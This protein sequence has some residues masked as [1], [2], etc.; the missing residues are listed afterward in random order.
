MRPV[1]SCI[2][3]RILRKAAFRGTALAAE[4]QSERLLVAYSRSNR[5]WKIRSLS[6]RNRPAHP[7]FLPDARRREGPSTGG[8]R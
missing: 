6:E 8:A 3:M 1:V 5:V 7:H 2:G 4:L